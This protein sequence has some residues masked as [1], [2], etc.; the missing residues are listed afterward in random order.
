MQVYI[1]ICY[2][3]QSVDF[4]SRKDMKS[5]PFDREV[6]AAAIEQSPLSTI[7]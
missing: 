1:L 5:S 3:H 7:I 2:Y 6:L 4:V